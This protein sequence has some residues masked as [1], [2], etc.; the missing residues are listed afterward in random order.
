M[1]LDIKLREMP[2]IKEFESCM[3]HYNDMCGCEGEVKELKKE[4][5]ERKYQSIILQNLEE[6]KP[7]LLD[8]NDEYVF[9]TYYP[10]EI[11]LA[12]IKK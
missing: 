7:Y 9:E 2:F 8:Y 6:M 12:K 5:C 10:D 11:I 3:L 1:A 4:E